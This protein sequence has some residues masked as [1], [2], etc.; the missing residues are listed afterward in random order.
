MIPWKGPLR[1]E[2]RASMEFCRYYSSLSLCLIYVRV[3]MPSDLSCPPPPSPPAL[4]E[5][6][7]N[8]QVKNRKKKGENG[9]AESR[10][11]QINC[12]LTDRAERERELPRSKT[13]AEPLPNKCTEQTFKWYR[14]IC[15]SILPCVETG[16]S[17]RIL[18]LPSSNE[19]WLRTLW[20]MLLNRRRRSLLSLILHES[21]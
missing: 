21:I 16:S 15:T 8:F 12:S 13:G 20:S 7:C 11:E 6:G 5:V 17:L 18:V 2:E 4:E 14:E 19:S 1:V 3:F 10:K 9:R